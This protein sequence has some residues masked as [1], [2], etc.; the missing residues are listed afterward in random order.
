METIN[1]IK[2]LNAVFKRFSE[3]SR[4]TPLHRSLYLALFE[5][6]NQKFFP[7]IFMI[8]RSV[9]MKLSKIRS[10]TTYHKRLTELNSFG[11]IAYY[12]SHDVF[13]GSEIELFYFGKELD[14]E[15]D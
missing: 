8:N 12:P 13:K 11:Y 7:K 10:R 4:I 6:W 5:L 15:M 14:H 1:Y 2:H 3:D 9:V